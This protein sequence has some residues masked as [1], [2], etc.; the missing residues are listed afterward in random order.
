MLGLVW[1]G[2]FICYVIIIKIRWGLEQLSLN[3]FSK[4]FLVLMELWSYLASATFAL[5][6]SSNEIV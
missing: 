3:F 5:F 2:S 4:F 1:I 6:F